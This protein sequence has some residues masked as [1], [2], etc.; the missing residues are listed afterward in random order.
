MPF[1]DPSSSPGI[2]SRLLAAMRS[3]FK[4]PTDTR[5]SIRKVVADVHGV[6]RFIWVLRNMVWFGLAVH[7]AFLAIFLAIGVWPLAA[8][9]VVSVAAYLQCLR[10]LRRGQLDAAFYI[11]GVEVG[12]H[13]ALATAF[14]GVASGFFLFVPLLTLLTFQNPRASLRTKALWALAE[15]A[16][17]VL[18][19]GFGHAMSPLTNLGAGTIRDL[20]LLNG[21]LL[22]GSIAF[23]SYVSNEAV[24]GAERNLRHAMARLDELARTDPLTGLLN[25]RAMSEL[26]Q[27][28]AL[29]VERHARPFAVMLADLDDF[30]RI[31]DDHGHG[32]GDH[33]LRS[34]AQRLLAAVRAQDQV[35]RWGGEEFLLLLPET[36]MGEA[37]EVADRLRHA[38]SD[39]PITSGEQELHITGTFGVAVFEK[40]DSI[41]AA[42][43]A[44]D[45]A[46]YRGKNSGK[47]RVVEGAG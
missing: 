6:E 12:L 35:A 27:A 39:A 22:V 26:L 37:L 23:L 30:K 42:I 33:A 25:R 13:A 32:V 46:L 38:V 20:A 19:L 10:L 36:D 5:T 44:A 43:R 16:T 34:I 21:A 47:N 41:H 3:R 1:T 7:F 4:R 11:G 18:L 9:N 24:Q 15:A 31:N 29:R 40:G 17:F 2:A 28:E 14:L 45:Q 8:F